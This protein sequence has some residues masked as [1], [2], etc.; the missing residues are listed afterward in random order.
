MANE[1]TFN[2]KLAYSNGFRADHIINTF[3]T[4][5]NAGIVQR[6]QAVPTSDTVVTLTGIT[7]PSIIVIENTDSTNYIDIGSTVTG[8]IAPLARLQPGK[9]IAFEAYPS[10]VVR[11]QAHTATVT[12]KISIVET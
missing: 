12:I 10:V 11:A 4:Q 6:I 2:M 7:T 5:T 1:V 8:A 3:L 9:W